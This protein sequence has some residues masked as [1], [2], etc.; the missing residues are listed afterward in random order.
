MAH[1]ASRGTTRARR[2]PVLREDYAQRAGTAAAYREARGITDPEQAVSLDP[3][4]E[5][6]LEALRRDT[7]RVLEIA[8]KQAELGAMTR[9]ELEGQVLDGERAQAT[10][11]RDV[12]SQLRLTWQAGA[13]AWQQSADA[14]AAHDQV[15]AANAKSLAAALDAFAHGALAR[16]VQAER[17]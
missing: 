2:L 15:Q 16:S 13:D 8:G 10:A 11:P 9:G 5:P 6:G 4:P 1:P 3:H 14:E 17:P 12:S 7:V